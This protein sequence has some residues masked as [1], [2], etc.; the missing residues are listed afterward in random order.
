MALSPLTRLLLT[1]ASVVVVLA[2]MRAAAPVIG[3]VAI[4]LLITIAWSPASQWLQRRGWPPLVASLTGTVVGIVV[5]ALLLLMIWSS[6]LQLQEN[7]PAYEPRVAALRESVNGFLSRLPFETSNLL[8]SEALQ[9]QAIVGYALKF[10]GGITSTAGNLAV[11]FLIM[12]FLMIEGVRYPQKLR[13]AFKASATST[14]RL[15]KFVQSMRS[16]VVINTIFGLIA[17]VANTVLLLALGVDLAIF[18]GVLSFLLS[19]L[20]NIGF[21]LALA[22]PALLALLQFGVARALMVVAG[23]TLLNFL[24]DNVIKPRHVGGSLDLSPAVVVVSLVF[25]GWLLGPVGALL[26]VPLTISARLLVESHEES[27]WVGHLLSDAGPRTESGS[28]GDAAQSDQ[29]SVPT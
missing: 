21:V 9:P 28:S 4:A 3:P 27:R 29:E 25:W 12:A 24:I 11:L 17:G 10:I 15:D 22:P 2:G 18:W 14:Q 26:A 20:P 1:M 8:D 16:Y 19:F 7:L 13:D 5:I 23:F 6:L